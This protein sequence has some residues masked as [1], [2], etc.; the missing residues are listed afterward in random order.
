MLDMNKDRLVKVLLQV[1]EEVGLLDLKINYKP[2]IMIVGGSSFILQDLS[3][4][5]VTHDIDVLR[6]DQAIKEI[7]D[8]YSIINS[9]VITYEDSLPYNYED[10]LIKLEIDAKNVEYISP[11]L[12]DLVVM[13]LYGARP[14]DLQDINSEEVINNIDW[15]M[16]DYLVFD[17]D[18]AYSSNF[19][20]QRYYEMVEEYKN[21][22]KEHNH[23]P[24][25]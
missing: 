8:K 7:I 14:N 16:M 25:V 11:S 13:K 12:E 22:A 9:Q 3:S 4:R 10:R 2:V 5:N 23:E 19:I 20:R 1:D 15:K 18:E 21:F 6:C 24:N 17:H